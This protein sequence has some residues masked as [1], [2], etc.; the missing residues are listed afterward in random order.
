LLVKLPS[1][2]RREQLASK[3][4]EV[5]LVDRG[6]QVQL[7]KLVRKDLMVSLDVKAHLVSQAFQA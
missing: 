5:T 2:L 6:I 7:G 3:E 1:H 4:K